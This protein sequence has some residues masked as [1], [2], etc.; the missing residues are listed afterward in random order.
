M[1]ETRLDFVKTSGGK[2][3]LKNRLYVDLL[4]LFVKGCRVFSLDVQ[5][6]VDDRLRVKYG[7]LFVRLP[8]SSF[9]ACKRLPVIAKSEFA[10]QS[11]ILSEAP[12]AYF[13]VILTGKELPVFY[14]IILM[15][16]LLPELNGKMSNSVLVYL[17][18]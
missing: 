4:L 12:G 7:S 6:H 13:T 14:A 2:S 8:I 1:F 10:E 17:L 15:K 11:S 9:N 16:V 5:T 3:I 18:L